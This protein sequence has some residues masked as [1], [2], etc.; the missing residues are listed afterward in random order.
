MKYVFKLLLHGAGPAKVQ[1][2]CIM[3][4][5][6]VQGIRQVSVLQE[7]YIHFKYRVTEQR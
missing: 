5:E 6:R 1:Q 7:Q 3:C 4:Q 2:I